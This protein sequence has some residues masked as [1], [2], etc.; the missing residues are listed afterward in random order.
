MNLIFDFDGTLVDTLDIH[1]KIANEYLKQSG[2][3]TVSK[4]D[5]RE[6][7]IKELIRERNIQIYKIPK[8]L[9]EAK[10]KV[11][12]HLKHV[13]IIEGM[14]EV[15]RKLHKN[16]KLGILTS[17]SVENVKMVLNNSNVYELFDFISSEFDIFGKHNKLR[18]IISK[19]QLDKK[20]TVY[21]GDETRDIEAAKR[22]GIKVFA[23]QWGYES[24]EVIKESKP[25]K[26]IFSPEEL[27]ATI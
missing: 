25:D 15:L 4:T 8:L 17:N 6:K 16:N 26:I 2:K 14:D 23:V 9:I 1:L 24:E 11:N 7:G 22:V 10:N 20:Q 18:K 12:K 19:Y 13:K 27:L 21:I 5:V 3:K